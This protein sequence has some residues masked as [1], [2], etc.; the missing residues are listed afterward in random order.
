MTGSIYD[1][2]S[3]W[4][5]VLK[6]LSLFDIADTLKTLV[7]VE[8]TCYLLEFPKLS[9]AILVFSDLATILGIMAKYATCPGS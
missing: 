4:N 1:I 6:T 9:I 7:F 3:K 5:I 2:S 8:N